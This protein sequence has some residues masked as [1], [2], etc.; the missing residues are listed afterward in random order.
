M[1]PRDFL[2][3][4][5]Q[6][7]VPGFD[8]L[9]QGGLVRNSV[10]VI[11]GGPGAGKTSFLMQ[12]LWNGVN[13]YKENGLYISFEPDVIELFKDAS[14]YGWDFEKLDVRGLCKFMKVSPQ[15]TLGELQKELTRAITKF[16]VKRICFDPISLFAATESSDLKARLSIFE[17]T[18]LFKRLGVTVL[19]S[20]ETPSQDTEG[21]VVSSE[22]SQ[23]VKFLTDGVIDLYSSGLGGVSDRAVRIAKMRRTN[24][25]RGPVPMQITDKGVVVLGKKSKGL[26][27]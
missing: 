7:G 2:I 20:D 23:F 24:H 5:C 22:R 19:L 10:N 21:G 15:T 8:D 16:G 12:F 18:S 6:T 17:L 26:G 3:E 25:S 13:M 4:R 9:C 11:L 14:A 27:L 1:N